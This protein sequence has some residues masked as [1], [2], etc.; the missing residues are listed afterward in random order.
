VTRRRTEAKRGEIKSYFVLVKEIAV[1]K[2]GEGKYTI[3]STRNG[4]KVLRRRV[5]YHHPS[6]HVTNSRRNQAQLP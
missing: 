3:Q 5:F 1:T 6:L 4:R 2:I